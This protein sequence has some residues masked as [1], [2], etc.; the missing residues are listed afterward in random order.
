MLRING[1]RIYLRDHQAS[2]LDVFHAWLSDPVVAQYLAWR[3]A[4]LEESLIQLAEALREN[5]AHPRTKYYFAIVLNANDQII[6]EAGFTIESRGESGGVAN[7]GYFLLK[8][9][10]GQ[11]Y[12]TEA[13]E[14]MIGYCFTVLGLHK[15]TAGC[16]AKNRA[17]E[18]V[19]QKC[20]LER[21][22]YRKQHFLL[23]GRWRDRLEYA[24]LY[25]DWLTS[26]EGS[27]GA[28]G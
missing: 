25:K 14:L 3:T 24:L 16:D 6:G 28:A 11:G 23:D 22:A 18:R 19:M 26:P 2:D 10:W 27:K 8:D 15:V 20:G 12:A 21:E 1:K 7:L 5:D 13:T 17:S 9:Y 4:T